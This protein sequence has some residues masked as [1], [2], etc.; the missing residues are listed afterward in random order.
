MGP[1]SHGAMHVYPQKESLVLEAG[2][3]PHGIWVLSLAIYRKNFLWSSVQNQSN[4]FPFQS[5]SR[6][7]IGLYE[8]VRHKW[9]SSLLRG[10]ILYIRVESPSPRNRLCDLERSSYCQW[11]LS[12][13]QALWSFEVSLAFGSYLW[14]SLSGPFTSLGWVYIVV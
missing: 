1:W 13:L 6:S 5:I 14:R 8:R 7:L 12:I 2:Q 10:V 3:A 11:R 9:K 4:S